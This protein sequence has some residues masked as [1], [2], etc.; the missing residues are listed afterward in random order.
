M[1]GF[2]HFTFLT[3]G[4]LQTAQDRAKAARFQAGQ[5]HGAAN[6]P[7][8]ALLHG[9]NGFE[10]RRAAA[11]NSGIRLVPPAACRLAE[12]V[13]AQEDAPKAV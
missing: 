13:P 9:E 4:M 11:K 10:N 1:W 5:I 8:T 7:V 3:L 12:N 6:L 2:A